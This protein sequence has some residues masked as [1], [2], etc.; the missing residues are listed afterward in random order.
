MILR[1]YHCPVGPSCPVVER[2]EGGIELVG[3]HRDDETLPAHE[4]RIFVPGSMLPE[5]ADLGIP[6]IG[7]WLTRHRKAPGDIVRIQVQPAYA[8]PSDDEDYQRYLDGRPSANPYLEAYRLQLA[9]ERR[10]GMV[11][12]NLV[13]FDGPP[14]DY[15][16]YAN[17]FVYR[18]TADDEHGQVVRVLDLADHPAARV[19]LRTGDFYVVEDQHVA[20]MRYADTGGHQGAVQVDGNAAGGYIAAA[21]FA[22]ELGT[23][24]QRWYAAHPEYQR[25]LR[26]A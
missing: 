7:A 14:T 4:R 3:E 10:Q 21:E 8:V 15:Q 20:L 24:F 9:D 25:R 12:R 1:N 2:V 19:L 18:L 13:V 6:D 17:E 11:W 23:P 16:R 22:W 26:A 5:L